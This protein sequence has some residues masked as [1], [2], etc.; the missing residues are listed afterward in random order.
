MNK[1]KA[2]KRDMR[3]NYFIIGIG[4]CN[5][6]WLLNYENP[7]AYSVG[8]Y[9]WACDYYDV[10]GVVISTGYSPLNNKNT[11]VSYE[12]IKSYNNKASLIISIGANYEQTRD[13]VKMLLIEFVREAKRNKIKEYN[14]NII[15]EAGL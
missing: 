7:V 5:A 13:A 6:Q 10:D 9:G 1:I 8:Q 3:D 4:Y 15:K 14:Q 12:M 2:T 11:L